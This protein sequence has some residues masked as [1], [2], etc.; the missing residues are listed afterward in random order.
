MGAPAL[1]ASRHKATI[2]AH[3]LHNWQGTTLDAQDGDPD[4][5][6]HCM[7]VHIPGLLRTDAFRV[8]TRCVREL[9]AKAGP[10]DASGVNRVFTDQQFKAKAPEPNAAVMP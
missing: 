1:G 9:V 5:S 6:G 2:A 3:V 10:I 7:A 4:T 8:Q